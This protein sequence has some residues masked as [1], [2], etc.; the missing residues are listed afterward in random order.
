MLHSFAERALWF[1]A[2][3]AESTAA[4]GMR[5]NKSSLIRHNV[6]PP[7]PKTPV[8][9]TVLDMLGTMSITEQIDWRTNQ[10][11]QCR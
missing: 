9:L 3:P 6:Q 2:E 7:S 5:V 10:P 1:H 11:A 4:S 8:N